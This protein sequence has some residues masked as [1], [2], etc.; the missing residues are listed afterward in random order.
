MLL[1]NLLRVYSVFITL[2]RL[3]LLLCLWT[4]FAESCQKE[5]YNHLDNIG[6]YSG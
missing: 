2:N 3:T 5:K 1:V 6:V 4:P